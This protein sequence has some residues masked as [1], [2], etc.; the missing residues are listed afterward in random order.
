MAWCWGRTLAPPG[1][2][3]SPTRTAV[4]SA[5]DP[6]SLNPDPAFQSNSDQDQDTDVGPGF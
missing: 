4:S 1:A 3:L 2:A 6:D 5:A